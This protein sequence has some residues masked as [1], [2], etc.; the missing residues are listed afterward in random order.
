MN[1]IKPN[2]VYLKNE[3]ETA[4]PLERVVMLYDGAIY[5]LEDAKEKMLAKKYT[6]ATISNIRAQNII[7][8]LKNSLNMD[9]GELPQRLNRLYAYFLKGLINANMERNHK[10]IEDIIKNLK[11]IRDSWIEVSKKCNMEG[12]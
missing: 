5:F 2:N 3:I 11:E 10:I 6:D 4:T 12:I 1:K 8:E 9:Y 7:I